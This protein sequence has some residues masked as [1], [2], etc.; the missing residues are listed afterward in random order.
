MYQQPHLHNDRTET[1]MKMCLD[2]WNDLRDE[3]DFQE[4]T[5]YVAKDGFDCAQR[6]MTGAFEPLMEAHNMIALAVIRACDQGVAELPADADEVCPVCFGNEHHDATCK[7]D[8]CPIEQGTGHGYA[9][10]IIPWS[11][12]RMVLKARAIEASNN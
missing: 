10:Y 7:D 3:I 4:L 1:D 8:E 12:G 6:L 11:V 5:E 2:H 9:D